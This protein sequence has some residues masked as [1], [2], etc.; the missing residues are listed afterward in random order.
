HLREAEQLTKQAQQEL[1]ALIQE[2]RPPV[3]ADKGLALALQELSADWSRG[4]GIAVTVRIQGETA[5][6]LPVEQALFRETQEALANVARHSSATQVEIQALWEDATLRLTI[7]DNGC[8]FEL[9][10]SDCKGMGLRSMR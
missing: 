1:G 7:E 8:G 3:L 10:K 5:L 2:L 4:T 9:A 6:P